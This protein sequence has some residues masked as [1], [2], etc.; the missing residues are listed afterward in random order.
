MR[1]RERDGNA[2][3]GHG[4]DAN[5]HEDDTNEHRNYTDEH[6]DDN[7]KAVETEGGRHQRESCRDGRAESGEDAVSA[8]REQY[9]ESAQTGSSFLLTSPTSPTSIGESTFFGELSLQARMAFSG[10]RQP[11]AM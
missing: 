1:G 3:D 7:G 6:E 4:N 10:R 2:V 8:W 5:E 11:L 9:D